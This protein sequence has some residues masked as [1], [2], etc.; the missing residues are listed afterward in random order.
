MPSRVV[1]ALHCCS[2]K[3]SVR[4][5]ITNSAVVQGSALQ[6]PGRGGA[7]G[8]DLLL[9]PFHGLLDGHGTGCSASPSCMQQP[10]CPI[11][12]LGHMWCGCAKAGGLALSGWG[13]YGLWLVG[14]ARCMCFACTLGALGWQRPQL[15]GVHLARQP[16]VAQTSWAEC[17]ISWETCNVVNS[18]AGSCLMQSS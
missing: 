17:W 7:A 10:V 13:V 14:F 8:A 2:T 15:S 16:A 6:W 9:E 5:Y 12:V 11:F 1:F 4:V 3:V 18:T